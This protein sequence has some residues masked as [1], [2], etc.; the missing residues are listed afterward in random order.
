MRHGKKQVGGIVSVL[1]I[2][3]AITELKC[4]I[5]GEESDL[6][7]RGTALAVVVGIF[8]VGPSPAEASASAGTCPNEALRSELRSGQLPDCRA[9]ERVTPAYMEGSIIAG[10]F[11]VSSDGSRVIAGSFGAFAGTEAVGLGNGTNLTSATYEFS[12]AD[13]VGWIPESLN[14]SPSAFRSNGMFDASSDLR[15]TLWELGRR[16]LSASGGSPE[17]SK[18]VPGQETQPEGVTDFYLEQPVGVFTKIGPATP[19]PCVVNGKRYF[20]LGASENLSHVLF[21][22]QPARLTLQ[23]SLPSLRW[24]F[25]GTVAGGGTLYD[26]AGIEQPDETGFEPSGEPKRKP[27]L[28][29]VDGGRGS[30]AL[31]SDCGTQ[32]GSSSPEEEE[33]GP[34]TYRGSM[35]NAISASGNR[36]FFTAVGADEASGEA[37]KGPPVGELFAREELASGELQTV[38]ISEP[39]IGYCSP[40]PPALPPA[41]ANGHFEGASLDGSKVFFTSTQKLVE[42]AS[43]DSTSGDNETEC[44]RTAGAGGCNLYEYD[45]EPD[46]RHGLIDISPG[47]TSGGG[48]Q[49]QGVARISE[50]GSHVYFVARGRLTNEPRSAACISELNAAERQE[51]ELT[52]EGRCRPKKAADN[53]YVY[54]EGRTSFIATLAPVT[55]TSRGDSGDWARADNRSVLASSDGRFLVFVSVAD[56]TGEG[57]TGEKPQVFQYDAASGALVRASIGQEG[58]NDNDRSPVAGSTIVNGFPIGYSYARTDSPTSASGVQ[59]PASGAVF[60]SSPDAL[61]PQALEDKEDLEKGL[62]PNI[63]EYDGGHVYLLSDGHD[64]ST[65]TGSPGVFLA[66]SDPSGQDVFFATSDALIPNDANTQQDLYDARVEG[67]FST[68]VSSPGCNGEACLDPSGAPDDLVPPSG[69]ALQEPEMATT[70]ATAKPKPLTIKPKPKL[71]T[72][73]RKQKAKR[74]P[75]ARAKSRGSRTL[76]R[77]RPRGRGAR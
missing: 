15:S 19:D 24:P 3:R 74:K 36:V 41:C 75:K 51:E 73:K 76:S 66:G 43:E 27:A 72:K 1:A 45:F 61:T 12:R 17:E 46:G 48:P 37:C 47:D 35:Y 13:G 68:S 6:S 63:Y 11:A 4:L 67:G 29:G 54:A 70:P 28:V 60:F 69:S 62:V 40:P 9:Y 16:S 2:Y 10:V 44:T 14:P 64:V 65:I 30:T 32:L 52:N 56:L 38:A 77:S 22:T 55:G 7:W 71:K 39:S 18:C 42:G 58:Y 33:R 34:A 53:L 50:D 26:Y 5:F 31:I 8:V 57:L 59:A 25:D 23:G 21:S 20:Y 49:V